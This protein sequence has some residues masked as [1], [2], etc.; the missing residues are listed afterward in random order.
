MNSKLAIAGFALL[1]CIGVVAFVVSR[2]PPAM[3]PMPAAPELPAEIIPQKTAAEF[4]AE[5]DAFF[6]EDVDPCIVEADKLNREAADRCVA[7]LRESFAGYRSGIA[8]FCEEINTWG[9]RLGVMRRMPSDWWYTQTNVGVFIQ[10]KFARHLFTDAELMKDIEEALD[11]FRGDVGANQNAMVLKIRAAVSDQD[12]PNLPEIQYADFVK[13]VSARLQTYNSDAAEKS[14]ASGI[15][16]EVASGAGGFVG[17]YLLAQLIVKLTS[18]AA[19]TTT[20]AGGATVGGA[21]IGGGSGTFLGGPVGT[22]VG[23]AV[24]LVIGGVIDWWMSNQFEAQMTEQLNEMID[25][26]TNTVIAGDDDRSGLR[27]GLRG[28]CDLMQQAY[29]SLLRDKI[30]GGVDS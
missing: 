12:L 20:G 9:T 3:P 25:G 26:L 21:T 27:D 7:R 28:S 13:E 8:P 14:V 5:R 10:E 2:P 1:L 16:I 18:M 17:E 6:T 11:Q 30:V 19:A 29:Q 23:I 15:A 24:G 22:A 4:R